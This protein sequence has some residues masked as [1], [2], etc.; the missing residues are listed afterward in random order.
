MRVRLSSL[1]VPLVVLA[2]ASPSAAQEPERAAVYS[3]DSVTTLVLLDRQIVFR[4]TERGARDVAEGVA[5]KPGKRNWNWMDDVLRASAS[6][7]KDLEWIFD[8]KDV[9]EAR[10]ERGALTLY[11]AT[12]PL[13]APETDR[14]DVFRY[15]DVPEDQAQTFIREFRRLKASR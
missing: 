6:G 12:R 15:E 3:R 10:Y 9:R 7:I 14:R 1:A 13:D 8:L 11:M 5:P 2:L 4:F